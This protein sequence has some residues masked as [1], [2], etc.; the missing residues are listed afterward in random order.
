MEQTTQLTIAYDHAPLERIGYGSCGSVWADPTTSNND[1]CY[2]R[3]VLK[4][5]DG[6]PDRSIENEARVHKHIL[7]RSKNAQ[8]VFEGAFSFSIPQHIEFLLPETPIW[9]DILPRLPAGSSACQA[10]ISERIPPMPH[11]V[12]RLLVERFWNGPIDKRDTILNDKRN[13]NCLI[14]PYLGRRRTTAQPGEPET[15]LASGEPRR[16][17]LQL[18]SLRNYPLHIDQV[19]ALGLPAHEYAG[20][21]ADALAFLLWDVQIDA[22]DVEFVLAQPRALGFLEHTDCAEGE[23]LQSQD[24]SGRESRTF[25]SKVLGPHALWILD[26]DCCQTLPMTIE[27]IERAAECFWRND[28]FY[29]NPDA[30]CERDMEVWEAFRDRFLSTSARIL[31]LRD[32]AIRK[33]PGQFITRV[34]E[35]VGMYSKG[36]TLGV[37]N[38]LQ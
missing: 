29:P 23:G 9:N 1:K 21:M 28:P 16:R 8:D 32:E 20:A 33:L 24:R 15:A 4:R 37:P 22:C 2:S 17:T 27:G 13:E 35:T 31:A 34:V 36:T 14:R 11:E 3:I 30:K 6:L 18:I 12:R 5:A 10:L 38:K 25:S 26:F 19:D 7:S